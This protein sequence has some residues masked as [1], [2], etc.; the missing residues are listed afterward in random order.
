MATTKVIL[1]DLN[2]ECPEG[3]TCGLVLLYDGD[4][5]DDAQTRADSAFLGWYRTR[6]ELDAAW[7][8]ALDMA[9]NLYDYPAI[10]RLDDLGSTQYVILGS[11]I[12]GEEVGPPYIG[13]A[14]K[15]EFAE[16]FAIEGDL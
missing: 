11:T 9:D 7:D 2:A 5:G 16:R 12:E 14:P 1:R 15:G 13:W 3:M 4:N 10:K 6:A 8:V